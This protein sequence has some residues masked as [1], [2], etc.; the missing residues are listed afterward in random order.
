MTQ[1]VDLGAGLRA[2]T[3]VDPVAGTDRL[4]LLLGDSRT[5]LRLDR[6]DDR[7]H[8]CIAYMRGRILVDVSFQ[9]G[10]LLT[11]LDT[12]ALEQGV[13][14]TR[15]RVAVVGALREWSGGLPWATT[16]GT[17]PLDQ[18]VLAAFGAI[19]HPL[20]DP[21]YALGHRPLSEVPRWALPMLHRS[22]P[23]DAARA[24]TTRATRR[25]ARCL[26]ASLV[27]RPL[28]ETPDF[29]PLALACAAAD[30]VEADELANVLEIERPRPAADTATADDARR[31][32]HHEPP[33]PTGIDDEVPTVD[34]VELLREMLR[35]WPAGRRAAVLNDAAR[36]PS[37]RD[38]V[39][40]FTHLRWVRD[41][42]E[43]PLPVR[44]ADLRTVCARHVPV[45]ADAPP[46]PA[47]AVDPTPAAARRPRQARQP[48]AQ[49]DEA[50]PTGALAWRIPR[51]LHRIHR[52]TRC[53]IIFDVPTSSTELLR[54]GVALDNCVGSYGPMVH[55]GQAWII[56]MWL[57]G[58][59]IGCIEVDPVDR[60][61]VQI[62]GPGNHPLQRQLERVAFE[63][64][65]DCGVTRAA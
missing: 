5:G 20:L 11:A 43:R 1:P 44:L 36:Q 57:H 6:A 22:T 23:L 50:L 39:T 54:W 38:V 29:V 2:A 61:V 35:L 3:L 10:A 8:A 17:V 65:H 27:R 15:W 30:L 47:P 16:D 42:V 14:P 45:L 19:T 63:A 60:S 13:D 26:A 24:L 59:L 34:D 52:H 33:A 28:H 40:L 25:V 56:G 7:V 48:R 49:V 21:V 41:R 18:V 46:T 62:E 9:P 4:D 37:F 64:L 32:D 51:A 55:G 53:G 12:T 58:S 31:R